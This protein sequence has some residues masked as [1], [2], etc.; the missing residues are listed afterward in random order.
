MQ[1]FNLP[2]QPPTEIEQV[3]RELARE[4][5]S[6][7]GC[8]EDLQAL[9]NNADLINEREVTEARIAERRKTLAALEQREMRAERDRTTG[10][11]AHLARMGELAL[12]ARQAAQKRIVLDQE[13]SEILAQ[14]ATKKAQRDQ[15]DAEAHSAYAEAMRP[16]LGQRFGDSALLHLGTLPCVLWNDVE[17]AITAH[18]HDAHSPLEAARAHADRVSDALDAELDN[19][20]KGDSHER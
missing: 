17:A 20:T 2:I 14:F 8:L 16:L 9:P 10:K 12:R 15:L 3:R 6:L 5:A 7:A 1:N 19:V 13:L 18:A 11:T 4:E